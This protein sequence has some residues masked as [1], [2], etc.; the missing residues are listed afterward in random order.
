[1][2]VFFKTLCVILCMCVCELFTYFAHSDQAFGYFFPDIFINFNILYFFICYTCFKYLLS[3]CHL[4][5][6]LI[7][8]F[9]CYFK[10]LNIQICFSMFFLCLDLNDNH[11]LSPHQCIKIFT[12][13][14]C[15]CLNYFMFYIYISN[16]FEVFSE[17]NYLFPNRVKVF[18][19]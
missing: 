19:I 3:I 11:K 6:I 18:I 16:I 1:M 14:F 9:L 2:F 7:T 12:Y 5:F 10:F 15:Y 13:V 8:L 17:S 4:S